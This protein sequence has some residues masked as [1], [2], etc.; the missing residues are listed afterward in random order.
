MLALPSISMRSPGSAAANVLRSFQLRKRR[1]EPRSRSGDVPGASDRGRP[2]Y[3]GAS[4]P[5]TFTYSRTPSGRVTRPRPCTT[6]AAQATP[7]V[8]AAAPTLLAG[9]LSVA[10]V[11]SVATDVIQMSTPEL[12]TNDVTRPRIPTSSDDCCDII[13][14]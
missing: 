10:S 13:N 8:L 6:G 7:G 11:L 9:T 12:S 2:A 4:T 5:R 1:P 14:T 3:R